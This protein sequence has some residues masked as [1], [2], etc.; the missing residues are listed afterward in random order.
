MVHCVDIKILSV[1]KCALLSFSDVS[2][3]VTVGG[4]FLRFKEVLKNRI[5]T[6]EILIN[7][8]WTRTVSDEKLL[9]KLQQSK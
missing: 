3:Y 9:H 8:Q 5:A 2:N 4:S 7:L 1:E 6:V